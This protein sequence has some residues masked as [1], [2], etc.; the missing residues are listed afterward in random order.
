MVESKNDKYLIE[1]IKKINSRYYLLKI[2]KKLW[3]IDYFNN[4]DL[5]N[6]FPFRVFFQQSIKQEWSIYDVT[7]KE[8]NYPARALHTVE[9]F[10]PGVC[11]LVTFAWYV[12][13]IQALASEKKF[14]SGIIVLVMIPLIT[15]LFFLIKKKKI[16]RLDIVN[17]PSFILKVVNKKSTYSMKVR[18]KQTAEILLF[19][20]IFFLSYP[21]IG[22][23]LFCLALSI[24]V[25]NIYN[26]SNYI[27]DSDKR[28]K[29]KIIEKEGN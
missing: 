8:N 4:Y 9:F 10:P 23:L 5:R 7:G 22:I 27:P 15:Y 25:F 2:N 13:T 29:Y 19:L 11:L 6:Y 14:F 28:I 17:Q 1:D 3:I 12:F 18:I 20:M 16:K 21:N 26:D 24:T